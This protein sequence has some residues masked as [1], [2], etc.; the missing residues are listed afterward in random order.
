MVR[1]SLHVRNNILTPYQLFRV[2]W[3]RPSLYL[4]KGMREVASELKEVNRRIAEGWNYPANQMQ[5]EA[6]DETVRSDFARREAV[7][8]K[9]RDDCYLLCELGSIASE[10]ERWFGSH[11]HFLT[12][13]ELQWL[14][15]GIGFFAGTASSLV[16]AYLL[17]LLRLNR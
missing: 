7:Y 9:T 1:G 10:L 6:D 4:L 8:Y 17:H 15:V 3:G 5:R 13:R 14:N 2:R 11:E 16:V 12:D